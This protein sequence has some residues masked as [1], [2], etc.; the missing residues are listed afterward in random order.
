MF[1]QDI[2]KC[3]GMSESAVVGPELHDA[4]IDPNVFDDEVVMRKP[5]KKRRSAQRLSVINGHLYN[6]EVT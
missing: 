1:C 2:P 3:N 4:E 5:V 6:A